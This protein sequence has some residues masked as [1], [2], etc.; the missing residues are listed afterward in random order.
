MALLL[1]AYEH[2]DTHLLY[3]NWQIGCWRQ[4]PEPCSVAHRA[5][6]TL[7]DESQVQRASAAH[8]TLFE[9]ALLHVLTHGGLRATSEVHMYCWPHMAVL[10]RPQVVVHWNE[11]A[12]HM[13]SLSALQELAS[14]WRN[15]HFDWHAAMVVREESHSHVASA[16]HD[17]AS[18]SLTHIFEQ[19]FVALSH[20]HIV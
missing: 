7:R 10:S 17:V 12:S 16:L 14:V 1:Y 11:E 20:L 19:R 15:T 3:A 2:V 8:V 9:Y 4:S 18:R 5:K 13:H 6:H